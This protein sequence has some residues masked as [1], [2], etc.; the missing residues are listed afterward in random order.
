MPLESGA[1]RAAVSHN[2]AT[3]I[4]AGKPPKQAEAIAFSKARGDSVAA[5][6]D[7]MVAAT[8]ALVKRL[9]AV[10]RK[11]AEFNEA[12]H[13]RDEDGKFGSGGGSASKGGGGKVAAGKGYN[14]KESS[15]R[16]ATKLRGQ[17][18]SVSISHSSGAG[19]LSSYMKVVDP[20]TGR[21]MPEIRLSD[22]LA[23]FR[24]QFNHNVMSEEETEGVVE[25]A[26]KMRALGPS[27]TMR[28]KTALEKSD[29]SHL[30]G[31]K[32]EKA[33]ESLRSEWE[34]GAA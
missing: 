2:I 16:L 10:A 17:G 34:P 26:K 3:E 6:V 7:A 5:R 4:R 24:S 13:P 22:H 12:D 30:T 15:E 14:P 33:I 9:D 19:G 11:D 25:A 23:G 20:E 27:T 32:R 8:D 1:S 31:K 29:L 28:Q 21:Y 18:F